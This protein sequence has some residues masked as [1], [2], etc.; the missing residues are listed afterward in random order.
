MSIK[1]RVD[2]QILIGRDKRLWKTGKQGAVV[3]TGE[4]RYHGRTG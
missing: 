4:A 2:G 3:V 1:T